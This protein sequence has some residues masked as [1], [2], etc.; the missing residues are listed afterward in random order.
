VGERITATGVEPVGEAVLVRRIAPLLL[1]HLQALGVGCGIHDAPA[2]CPTGHPAEHYRA[3]VAEGLR[4]AAAR[5]ATAAVVL[6]LHLNAGGGR[7]GMT[8]TDPR[9]PACR[10]IADSV[11][12]ELRRALGVTAPSA[13]PTTAAFPRAAG[14]IETV[15][16]EG[17]AWPGLT[18]HAL[19]CEPLFVDNRD[20][21][22]ILALETGWTADA[23]RGLNAVAAS[24]ARGLSL[25]LG[26]R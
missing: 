6:H 20:H 8:V 1:L 11:D 12:A 18:A 3:R 17:R 24:I 5:Q 14:L 2:P 23:L 21:Q 26:G 22:S 9:S 16:R 10:A 7:Y 4:S 13:A 19:V 25:T 15:W